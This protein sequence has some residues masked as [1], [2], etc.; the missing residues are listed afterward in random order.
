MDAPLCHGCRERDARIAELQARVAELEARNQDQARLLIDLARK[1]Q[2]KDLPTTAPNGPTPPSK[3]A[4]KKPS[5]HKPGA[6]P[7]HPPHLKQLLPP[8]RVTRTVS[9]VPTLCQHCRTPLPT[10][11]GPEDPEPTRFQVAELPELKA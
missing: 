9:F 2:D 4:S 11:P 8:E 5:G 1:L 7:G 6:Q 10:D 3:P